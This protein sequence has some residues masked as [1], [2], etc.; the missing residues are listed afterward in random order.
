MFRDQ[1]KYGSDPSLIRR[2]SD[3]TFYAPLRL[4]QSHLIFTCSWSDF[5]LKEG[6]AWRDE[7][8]DVMRRTP[9][10]VY[11]V[12]T[13]RPKRITECLPPHWGHGWPHV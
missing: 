10:H 6:D 3:H 11:Q 8:W 7:A 1:V 2:T 12:L 9:H 5:F 13:K 4:K